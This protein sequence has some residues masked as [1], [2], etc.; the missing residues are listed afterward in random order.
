MLSAI[1]MMVNF[2]HLVSE[3]QKLYSNGAG[4]KLTGD[5]HPILAAGC[6]ARIPVIK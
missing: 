6:G 3:C 1:Q 2:Y 4:Y 5:L